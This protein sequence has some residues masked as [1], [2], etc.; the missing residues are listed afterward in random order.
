MGCISTVTYVYSDSWAVDEQN[1]SLLVVP[2]IKRALWNMAELFVLLR[3][4]ASCSYVAIPVLLKTIRNGK[5]FNKL[6]AFPNNH[7]WLTSTS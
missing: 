1:C 7:L 2:H 6:F 5:P 4:G 3:T